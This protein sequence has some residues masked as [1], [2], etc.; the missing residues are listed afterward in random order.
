MCFFFY[1]LVTFFSPNLHG[2]AE[3]NKMSEEKKRTGSLFQTTWTTND[4]PSSLRWAQLISLKKFFL[5]P[6]D[7]ILVVKQLPVATIGKFNFSWYLTFLCGQRMFSTLFN[8]SMLRTYSSYR[9]HS[10]KWEALTFFRFSIK[11]TSWFCQ[12]RPHYSQDSRPRSAISTGGMVPL[13]SPRPDSLPL[14]HCKQALKFAQLNF[15]RMCMNGKHHA[16]WIT[17]GVRQWSYRLLASNY[18]EGES[19]SPF[20]WQLSWRN[21]NLH[22]TA[23]LQLQVKMQVL[24]PR[25]RIN[26]FLFDSDDF[27]F[28]FFFQFQQNATRAGDEKHRKKAH[29]LIRILLCKIREMQGI[30]GQ[31]SDFKF[32]G[33]LSAVCERLSQRSTEFLCRRFDEERSRKSKAIDKLRCGTVLFQ[34]R[35]TRQP[36]HEFDCRTSSGCRCLWGTHVGGHARTRYHV[37]HALRLPMRKKIWTLK[38]RLNLKG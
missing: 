38:K 24:C 18:A 29:G 26:N 13:G 35:W 3:K 15:W 23:S 33:Q 12:G 5:L 14:D 21:C 28:F 20:S 32:G 9:D 36:T 16:F 10:P 17:N 37:G 27:F 11:H 22:S 7:N 2:R 30:V 4:T 1:V 19:F 8:R 25:R 34:V 6:N 31:A